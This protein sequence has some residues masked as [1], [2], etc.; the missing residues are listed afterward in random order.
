MA[1]VVATKSNPSWSPVGSGSTYTITFPSGLQVGDL[2]V[3]AI[4]AIELDASSTPNV[5]DPTDWTLLVNKTTDSGENMRLKVYYKTATAGDVSAGSIVTGTGVGGSENAFIAAACFRITGHGDPTT[6]QQSSAH[7][8]ATT[9][10]SFAIGLTPTFADSLFIFLIGGG[11][12]FAS[13]SASGYAMATDNPTW[14][15]QFDV[16][17]NTTAYAGAGDND[18]LFVAATASRSAVTATGNLSATMVNFNHNIGALLII[19]PVANA[20]VAPA[21]VGATFSSQAP[22]VVGS[23]SVSADVVSAAH[24][25]V[26]PTVAT[27]AQRVTNQS[28]NNVSVTNISKS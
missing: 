20:S 5:N 27:P 21:V 6:I 26:A 14:T 13:G 8:A 17:D 11:G 23:A 16:Y 2:M 19:P 9:S 28:K 18:G 3:A 24:S 25:V 1:V 12:N 4:H 7:I 15:E 22:A 10:P